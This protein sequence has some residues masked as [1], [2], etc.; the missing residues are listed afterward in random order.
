MWIYDLL[1]FHQKVTFW[2]Q[3]P[4]IFAI[5][6]IKISILQLYKRVFPTKRLCL[7]ANL[8]GG[9][10]I[11]WTIAFFFASLFQ[12]SPISYNWNSV[13]QSGTT[14]DELALYTGLAGSELILDVA[15]LVLPWSVVWK[16]HMSTCRKWFVSSVFT[17]GGLYETLA[18][19]HATSTNFVL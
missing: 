15:T 4:Y 14:V 9:I 19:D 6:F 16:L 13:G 8:M 5:S 11:A 3:F 2:T 7:I 12:A 10:I 17:L 1:T 18:S